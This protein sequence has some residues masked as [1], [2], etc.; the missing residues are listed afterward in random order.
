MELNKLKSV[1]EALILVSEEPLT[2]GSMVLILEPEG[3]TKDD[4]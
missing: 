1:L 2:F 3:V 4:I